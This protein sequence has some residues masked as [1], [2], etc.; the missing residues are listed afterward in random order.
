AVWHS[1]LRRSTPPGHT[2]GRH[3]STSH[4]P[5][6]T[7]TAPLKDAPHVQLKVTGRFPCPSTPS[8]RGQRHP[9]ASPH[10]SNIPPLPTL[11]ETVSEWLTRITSCSMIG[12]ASSSAV[13]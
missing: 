6:G 9:P 10:F 2:H 5:P 7:Q 12:P 11:S 13:T 4:T 8:S 1:G 3:P